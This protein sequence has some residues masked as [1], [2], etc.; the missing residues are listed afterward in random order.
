MQS[1]MKVK[2]DLFFF[3][4]IRNAFLFGDSNS[5]ISVS[6]QNCTHVHVKFF[7]L[8][9]PNLSPP[10]IVTFPPLSLCI[11]WMNISYDYVYLRSV[12]YDTITV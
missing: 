5:S 11:N 3:I 8:Q 12:M 7:F 1:H 9:L 6:N 10:K 4:T 2:F